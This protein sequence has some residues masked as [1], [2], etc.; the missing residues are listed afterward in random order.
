MTHFFWSNKKGKEATFPIP[1][2][3]FIPGKHL[4]PSTH[5]WSYLTFQNSPMRRILSFLVFFFSFRKSNWGCERRWET[6]RRGQPVG[7]GLGLKAEA[8]CLQRLCVFTIPGLS[9][10]CLIS[11]QVPT[12]KS[13]FKCCWREIFQEPSFRKATFICWSFFPGIFPEGAAFFH[14]MAESYYVKGKRGLGTAGEQLSAACPWAASLWQQGSLR[15][16]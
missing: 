14:W 1:S 9:C 13:H 4:R 15:S 11:T 10:L 5:T 3:V 2:T 12:W 16:F 6:C 8:I 7:E